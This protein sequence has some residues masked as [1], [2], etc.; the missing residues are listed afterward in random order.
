MAIYLF[1]IGD[2]FYI[3]EYTIEQTYHKIYNTNSQ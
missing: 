2:Y 3:F 1:S